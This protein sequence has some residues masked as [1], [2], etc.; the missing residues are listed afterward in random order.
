MRVPPFFAVTAARALC[1]VTGFFRKREPQRFVG[2]RSARAR[3]AQQHVRAGRGAGARVRQRLKQVQAVLPQVKMPQAKLA[4]MCVR[5]LV[6]GYTALG[7][8]REPCT[9]R[10]SRQTTI[11]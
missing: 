11:P 6:C 9:V 3:R 10:R 8:A 2:G 7:A 4:E 5:L 1:A